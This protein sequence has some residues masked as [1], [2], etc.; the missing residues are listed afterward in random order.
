[1][2]ITWFIGNGFDLNLGLKTGYTDFRD[3]VYLSDSLKSEKRDK[4]MQRLTDNERK[5]LRTADLWSDL[6][7]LLGRSSDLY[8]KDESGLF[9]E[10]FEEMEQL[11]SDYVH[12]Q[13]MRLPAVLPTE[14]INEFKASISQ[15]DSRMVPQDQSHFKLDT[16]REPI[17][18][19]F[20]SLNYTQALDRFVEAAGDANGISHQRKTLGG[21]Y[22]DK[23]AKPFY[24]H[25]RLD[26][27]SG[28]YE[29]VFGVDSPEQIANAAF[30]QDSF[31][32]E[33]WVKSNRNTS[34]FDN[35]NEQRL[36]QLIDE[37]SVICIYGCSMGES[38]GRIWRSIGEHLKNDG[39]SK[40]VLFG[41]ELPA[42]SKHE[43]LR[44]QR[45]REAM[46][47][48]F[49]I[50]A[51]LDDDAMDALRERIFFVPS[52]DYFKFSSLIELAPDPYAN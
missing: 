6:E 46:K 37:A 34:L 40:L 5:G 2:H 17:L 38:D 27:T 48:D 24:L 39:Y 32:V 25:G 21:M 29:V 19:K 22:S 31:F 35:T 50:A 51:E 28:S 18:Q 11:L 45:A 47:T 43:H 42:R 13:E 1:M 41:Y 26:A 3:H 44:Y 14:C 52:Q 33:S 16:A 15:F 23:V 36:Q 10:T 8:A 7:K 4:L 20:V 12:T 30:A 49:Q 9:S